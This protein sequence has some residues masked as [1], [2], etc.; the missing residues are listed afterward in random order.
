[1]QR[2]LNPL[3]K[4]RQTVPVKKVLFAHSDS[5]ALTLYTQRSQTRLM[6]NDPGES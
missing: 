4:L 3:L 5:T 2:K 6:L 1:M